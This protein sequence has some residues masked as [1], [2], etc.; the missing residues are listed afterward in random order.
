MGLISYRYRA[1]SVACRVLAESRWHGLVM[2]RPRDC[3]RSTLPRRIAFPAAVR[4]I[5]YHDALLG[6]SV[7]ERE[8]PVVSIAMAMPPWRRQRIVRMVPVSECSWCWWS[9]RTFSAGAASIAG[10]GMGSAD[11]RSITAPTQIDEIRSLRATK[12]CCS[13]RVTA[14]RQPA[15]KRSVPASGFRR[16]GTV[17]PKR[18]AAS[19]KDHDALTRRLRRIG[20]PAVMLDEA[21]S[22]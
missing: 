6:S 17:S 16:S 11:V 20:E 13:K 19:R 10:S 2:R 14:R 4:A 8:I 3:P 12:Q 7:A 21:A 22:P 9:A 15:P 1:V 5:G 18:L